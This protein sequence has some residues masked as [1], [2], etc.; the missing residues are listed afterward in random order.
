MGLIIVGGIKSIVNFAEAV[1]PSMAVFYIIVAFSVI[2]MNLTLLPDIFMMI[3]DSAF[4]VKSAAAG[5]IS[6]SM[7]LAMEQGIKRGLFSQ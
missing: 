6:Y 5:G 1:V 3:I 4:G 2:C 7:K